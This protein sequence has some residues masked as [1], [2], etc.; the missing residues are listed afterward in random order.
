MPFFYFDAS[1]LVKRYVREPGS[2]WTASVVDDRANIIFA[3]DVALAE[4]SAAFAI[5]QRTNQLTPRVLRQALAHFYADAA[6]RYQLVT[7]TRTIAF[8]AAELAQRY[9]LKGYDAVHLATALSQASFV[10][11]Y[12]E[13][14]TFIS[15]DA[16]LLTAARA[17]GLVVE[18]PFDHAELDS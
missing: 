12:G 3:S 18:N 13:P 15:G 1:V 5:L 10:N 9:P 6:H 4:V 16:Q 11:R 7:L 8:Q 14:L 2:S 17:A